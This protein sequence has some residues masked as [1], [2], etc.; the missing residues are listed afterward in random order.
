MYQP[1]SELVAIL[2]RARRKSGRRSD[3]QINEFVV[4]TARRIKLG[5]AKPRPSSKAGIRVRE[6]RYVGI[7][8][9]RLRSVMVRMNDAGCGTRAFPRQQPLRQRKPRTDFDS[10]E[11]S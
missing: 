1:E 7:D 10:V 3:V 8:M 11:D 2:E 9:H 6:Q 5:G 4:A